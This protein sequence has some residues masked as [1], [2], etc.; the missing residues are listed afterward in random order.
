VRWCCYFRASDTAPWCSSLCSGLCN[1]LL[2]P[3]QD[4]S[5]NAARAPA[6]KH[7]WSSQQSSGLGE[8]SKKG[9]RGSQPKE[10]HSSYLVRA[11][12]LRSLVLPYCRCRCIC[13]ATRP[14]RSVTFPPSPTMQQILRCEMQKFHESVGILRSARSILQQCL[15]RTCTSR[16]W[17]PQGV[18]QW[19]SDRHQ[20]DGRLHMVSRTHQEY[21][22]VRIIVNLKHAHHHSHDSLL[23]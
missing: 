18:R 9:K 15:V 17:L 8:A 13:D 1:K 4:A 14:F 5:A 10:S 19:L 6:F 21:K 23:A 2:G 11:G 22:D 16:S 7:S 3:T 20:N 12:E